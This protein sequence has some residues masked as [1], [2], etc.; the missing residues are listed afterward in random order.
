MLLFISGWGC[1]IGGAINLNKAA[2]YKSGLV[3]EA[4][5]ENVLSNLPDDYCI[6]IHKLNLKAR[7]VRIDHLVV[8]LQG[9]LL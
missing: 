9:C 8:G 6:S 4:T 1:V 3:G 5:S 2:I 7:K